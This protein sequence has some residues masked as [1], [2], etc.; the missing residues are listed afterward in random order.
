MPVAPEVF[1]SYAHADDEGVRYGSRGW[2]ECFYDALLRRLREVRGRETSIW[3]DEQGR[4]SGASALT[5]TIR[6]GLENASALI[7]I[8]SPSYAASQWCRDEFVFFRDAHA[9]RGGLTVPTDDGGTMVRV[10][11]VNKLPLSLHASGTLKPD[12]IA[13]EAELADSPGFRFHHVIAGRPFEY[14]PPAE[15]DGADFCRAI[16]ALAY[17]IVR[18]LDHGKASLP[19]PASGISVYLAAATSDLAEHREKIRGALQ[20]AG[21]TV[22]SGDQRQ[23]VEEVKADLGRARISV[24]LIGSAYG[25]IPERSTVSIEELE[26]ALAGAERVRPGFARLSWIA[27]DLDA[28]QVEARQAA[29]IRSVRE[30]DDR[31]AAVSLEDFKTIV[32]DEL[33]KKPETAPPP[34]TRQKIYLIFDSPDKDAAESVRRWLYEQGFAVPK[35]LSSG[36]ASQIREIHKQNL[37]YADGV[38]IY[39]GVVNEY[40]VQK[41]LG[42]LEQIYGFGRSRKK[43]MSRGVYLADPDDGAKHE[44]VLD[45]EIH[46]IPGFGPFNPKF[47]MPFLQDLKLL[48]GSTA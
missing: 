46:V 35:P 12:F 21:H 43:S 4:I 41:N 33:A 25:A 22:I 45:P 20:Q 32:K 5:P 38:L 31:L 47:L 36:S 44:S 15:S 26:Y 1:L 6:H 19:V 3:L 48:H 24:H 29:F 14:V 16:N 37:K 17:D 40:F 18:L 39:Y 30:S 11:M 9:Q 27:P 2:V 10:F 42:D 23:T 34:A 13:A 7:T 8:V 28:A